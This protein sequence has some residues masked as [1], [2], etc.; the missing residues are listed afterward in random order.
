[1]AQT[2][3]YQKET[4]RDLPMLVIEAGSTGLWYKLVKDN[5]SVLGIDTFGESGKAED[6]FKHFGFTI[7]N[8]V[9]QAKTLI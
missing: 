6:L 7:E 3:A 1:M 2:P 9:K 8:V 5:G 4:L